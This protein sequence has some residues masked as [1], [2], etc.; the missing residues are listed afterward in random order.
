M[1]VFPCIV[2]MALACL[3]YRR[4]GGG[5]REV[6]A[7]A[8]TVCFFFVAVVTEIASLFV[9]L[10]VTAVSVFWGLA[11]IISVFVVLIRYGS[12]GFTGVFSAIRQG[13]QD[14]DRRSF[15]T[16]T[17]VVV[18][19]GLTLLIGLVTPPNNWDA[20]TYHMSRVAHWLQQGHVGFYPTAIARQ[21]Y[22]MPLAE[23]AILHLQLLSGSDRFA[24]LVQWSAW[25]GCVL[26]VSLVARELGADRR[27]Q[28]FAALLAA[29]LPMGVLQACSTQ[30][31][32]VTA[33]FCLGLA[34]YLI[35][36]SKTQ[37]WGFVLSAACCWGL[38]LLTKGT[39]CLYS[40][41]LIFTWGLYALWP[42]GGQDWRRCFKQLT[43][44]ALVTLAL[45]VG[46]LTRNY[47]LYGHPLT[48]VEKYQNE[49]MSPTL[50]FA[51][52]VR[53]GALH[54]GLPVRDLNPYT[55]RL[56]A[57]LLGDQLNNPQTTF[58]TSEFAI[59]STRHEDTAGNLFHFM[60]IVL[61]LI[62]IPLVKGPQKRSIW[63]YAVML[64]LAAILFSVVLKWQPWGG[65]LHT[66]L[67]V[68]AMPLIPVVLHELPRLSEKRWHILGI[69]LVVYCVPYLLLNK[70]RPL[71]PYKGHWIL[72]DSR[73]QQYFANQPELYGDYV[74][75]AQAL[76]DRQPTRV[77]LL[78]GP[79]DWEYPLWVLMGR[80]VRQGAPMVQHVGVTD[81]SRTLLSEKGFLPELVIVTRREVEELDLLT[82]YRCIFESPTASVLQKDL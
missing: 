11:A 25:C 67:F 26:W 80:H 37:Q 68:L 24:H 65:R 77:G 40:T 71:I 51:N 59:P 18:I 60:L 41:A 3:N 7:Q 62:C 30:N 13:V 46:H 75:V 49:R 23:F 12:D 1:V 53:N 74:A 29:T 66:P 6:F 55:E 47:G 52:L 39:A 10:T 54:L 21:N 17:V 61:A 22:Q 43:V 58:L 48:T 50:L 78:L 15:Q 70:S 63:G 35:R 44:L 76:K 33:F 14:L 56:I 9:S 8:L 57:V 42:R 79:D 36:L 34:Y 31:D 81:L 45:N 69:V 27:K 5:V 38:A 73:I 82:T 16:L 64:V 4:Q 19:A 32:L 2:L 72:R 20:M 28:L